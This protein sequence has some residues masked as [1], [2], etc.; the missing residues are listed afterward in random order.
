MDSKYVNATEGTLK[1]L[2]D[3]I[4][5]NKIDSRNYEKVIEDKCNDLKVKTGVVTKFYPYLDKAE[6]KLD[7]SKKKIICK[8]LHRY[9]GDMIDLYTPIHSERVFDE[10][11]KEPA[12]IPRATNNV[13]VLQIHDDVNQENLIIGYYQSNDIVGYNPAK[14]G[15]IKL[16]SITEPNLYWIKFGRDGLELRLP[17]K[18]TTDVGTRPSKMET[19]EYAEAK[20]T[21]TKEQV[22]TKQDLYT[23]KEVEDL[24]NKKL[25]E[26]LDN[27]AGGDKLFND[28]YRQ[29]LVGLPV[30]E[31]N[32]SSQPNVSTVTDDGTD[33]NP[34]D[35]ENEDD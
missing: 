13:C 31:N 33:D 30:V 22:Y 19:V 28:E 10:K 32:N 9:G 3:N 2:M 16:M 24:I 35:D 12:L 7:K 18:K 21:Y 27:I 11:L 14:P 26:L 4:I 5:N 25:L 6:V 17:K 29:K 8:I 34:N 20:N 23:K 15:N 1:I